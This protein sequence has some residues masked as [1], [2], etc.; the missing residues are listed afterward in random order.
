MGSCCHTGLICQSS[1]LLHESVASSS[2]ADQL[3]ILLPAWRAG[4]SIPP[5]R[6][7]PISLRVQAPSCFF[8]SYRT[9]IL[10]YLQIKGYKKLFENFFNLANAT[11]L[12]HHILKLLGTQLGFNYCEK[13]R[14][15]CLSVSS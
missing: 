2:A 8:V 15:P 13:R 3:L 10:I 7:E 12:R 11:V 9:T 6:V 4:L 14:P 5:S 1:W